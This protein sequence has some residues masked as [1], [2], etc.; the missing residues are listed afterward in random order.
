MT[1]EPNGGD[2][3]A[4]DLTE[5]EVDALSA[6]IQGG[7]ARLR[8]RRWALSDDGWKAQL[9]RLRDLGRQMI[10]SGGIERDVRGMS[11]PLFQY[12]GESLAALSMMPGG[13][14][15]CEIVFCARH[16]PA[17]TEARRRLSCPKCSPDDTLTAAA[18][19]DPRVVV[20]TEGEI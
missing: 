11:N 10:A 6:A 4:G 12:A 15:I 2:S 18:G 5:I 20:T 3:V 19:R 17:G 1:L 7:H 13:V 14:R 8:E 9:R 16:Y